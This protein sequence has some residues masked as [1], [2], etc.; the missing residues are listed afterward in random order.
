MSRA[1]LLCAVALVLD[2]LLLTFMMPGLALS[3][4]QLWA[5]LTAHAGICLLFSLA[6]PGLLPQRLRQRALGLFGFLGIVFMPVLGMLG[7]LACIVP[8]W[9]GQDALAVHAGGWQHTRSPRLPAKP[10]QRSGA[11]GGLAKGSDLAGPLQHATDPR[12]R[13]GALIATL[14]LEDQQAVPLLRLALKDPDDEVRLL[15]YALLNRKEKAVE[16]RMREQHALTA[17]D[18]PERHFLRHKALAHDYWELAHL[19]D[20][21]GD[22]LISLCGRAHEHAQA[23]L[24]LRPQDGGLQFL[25]GQIF[26]VQMQFDAASEAFGAAQR[27]GI[28]ARQSAAMLAEIAFRRQRY[29]DVPRHLAQAGSGGRQFALDKLSSYWAGGAS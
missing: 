27:C 5:L 24:K 28:D 3:P 2:A 25:A 19:G 15:A 6:L 17:G 10:A 20:P 26:L 7:L 18:A 12:K 14:S 21:H 4:V 9:R 29:A 23:A 8:V 1:G 16:A 22:A 13:I 11:S